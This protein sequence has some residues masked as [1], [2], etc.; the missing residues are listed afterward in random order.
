MTPLHNTHPAIHIGNDDDARRLIINQRELGSPWQWTAFPGW[1]I[2]HAAKS[3]WHADMVGY[4]NGA[5]PA[6]SPE[7]W[8][9]RRDRR[10]ALNLID[11]APTLQHAPTVL[12]TLSHAARFISEQI[13]AGNSILVHCNQGLSRSPSTVLWWCHQTVPEEPYDQALA[14][15]LLDYPH[16]RTDSGVMQLVKESWNNALQGTKTE[17]MVT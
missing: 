7:R 14:N 4:H 13:D 2:V 6:A 17:I 15:L 5:A 8:V 3:P 10:L 12:Q 9:A 11:A 16:V 1:A